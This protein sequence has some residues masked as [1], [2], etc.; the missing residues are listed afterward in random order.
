MDFSP[1][2]GFNS[3]STRMVR[4]PASLTDFR[5]NQLV[6]SLMG[7]GYAIYEQFSTPL[8]EFTPGWQLL[9]AKPFC[10]NCT[11]TGESKIPEFWIEKKDN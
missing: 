2:D 3:C 1:S 9:L 8:D 4:V 10:F 7:V 11:L 6:D 5:Q